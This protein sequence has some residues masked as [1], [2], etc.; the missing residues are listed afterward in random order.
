MPSLWSAPYRG[1]A[2]AQVDRRFGSAIILTRKIT[3][4]LCEV[5]ELRAVS[6][7]P[8]YP[9]RILREHLYWITRPL[10]C[11][12]LRLRPRLPPTSA[13]P[14]SV[15]S[16]E[17]SSAQARQP[18]MKLFEYRCKYQDHLWPVVRPTRSQPHGQN[19]LRTWVSVKGLGMSGGPRIS[20]VLTNTSRLTSTKGSDMDR[21]I[22]TPLRSRC[23]LSILQ[24]D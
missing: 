16:G 1:I 10:R 13:S 3:A 22:V 23:Y 14:L 20:D 2:H 15:T 21:S 8:R 24:G 4:D 11:L 18:S 9:R 6:E 12:R 17:F 7:T 5:D 19:N